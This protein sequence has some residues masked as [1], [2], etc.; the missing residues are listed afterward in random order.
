MRNWQEGNHLFSA[1]SYVTLNK[2]F[3]LIKKKKVFTFSLLKK[4]SLAFQ[5][6]LI[7]ALVSM[8]SFFLNCL[9]ACFLLPTS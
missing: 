4:M 6:F 8:P 7:A 5:I 9:S 1:C 2:L 3:C